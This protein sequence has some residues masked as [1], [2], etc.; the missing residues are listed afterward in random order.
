M[1]TIGGMQRPAMSGDF[2]FQCVAAQALPRV[3]TNCTAPK[4]MLKRMV[5]KES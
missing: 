3:A 1:P 5:W 2:I 4:G